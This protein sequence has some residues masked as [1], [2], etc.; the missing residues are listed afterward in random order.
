MQQVFRYLR[1]T[2]G[3]GLR[4]WGKNR[5]RAMLA[6]AGGE[7]SGSQPSSTA[8]AVLPPRVGKFDLT[9][10]LNSRLV[11]YA[12]ADYARDPITRRSTTGYAFLLNGAAVSWRVRKQPS[13]ALSTCEAEVMSLCDAAKEAVWL[14]RLLAELGC[15]QQ[16]PTTILEDNESAVRVASGEALFE[17]SKHIDIRVHYLRDTVSDHVLRIVPCATDYMAADALTKPLDA[18]KV[19]KHGRRLMGDIVCE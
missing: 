12:D 4:Y 2:V 19:V 5:Q 8:A 13:V 15:E 16:G 7:E 10:S 11:G 14:R 6:A 18:E 9:D 1:G 17:R 3:R